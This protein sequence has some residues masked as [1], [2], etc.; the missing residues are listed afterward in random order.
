MKPPFC[1]PGQRKPDPAWTRPPYFCLHEAMLEQLRQHRV[2]A[3]LVKGLAALLFLQ[4]LI[5][6]QAHAQYR[7]NSDGITVVVCTLQGTKAV[8]IDLPGAMKHHG[9]V[10]A[11]MLFSDLLNNISPVVAAV[12][13]PARV[14]GWQ[15]TASAPSVSLPVHGQ[16]VP[17]SR[18]PPSA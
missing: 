18:G 9:H 5:P 7:R 10:S 3:R 16:P 8:R 12:R 14:L 13:P 2:T 1:P 15:G 17:A 11:A 6:L 4:M